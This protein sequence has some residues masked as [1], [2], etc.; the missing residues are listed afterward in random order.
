MSGRVPPPVSADSRRS[1]SVQQRLFRYRRSWMPPT[2]YRPLVVLASIWVGLLA[3]ALFA[4]GQLVH[5]ASDQGEAVIS[6]PGS[7]PHERLQK[8]AKGGNG[9]VSIDAAGDSTPT[10]DSDVPSV[11]PVNGLSE[12]TLLA[13]VG[14]CAG[15]CW[16]LSILLKR[17]RKR[18]SRSPRRSLPRQKYRLASRVEST[19][20]AATSMRLKNSGSSA[21]PSAGA[22]PRLDAYNPQQP[23][24]A[25]E[26]ASDAAKSAAQSA[27]AVT[28]HPHVSVVPDQIQHRLDWPQDSLVNTADVR[29]RRSLSSYL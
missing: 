29:Q 9:P 24:V 6:A 3:I 13:L 28:P 22:I 4:Y 1:T 17:P 20:P 26:P 19:P 11:P 12:W 21:N 25:P 27:P 7:D 5:T 14:S 8:G 23:L 10:L 2:T 18:K 16:V 15:G